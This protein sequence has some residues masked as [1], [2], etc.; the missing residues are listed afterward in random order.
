[1]ADDR[2]QDES[3]PSEES[4]PATEAEDVALLREQ[5]EEALREKDQFRA[6]AQRA[7]ADLVNYK[8]RSSDEQRELKRVANANQLLKTLSVVDDLTRALDLIPENAVAPGWLD[9]L[10][11]V[12][13]NLDNFLESEGV[14]KIEAEGQPF[15]PREHEAVSFEDTPDG[16][17]GMVVSVIR[18][19]YKLHDKVLRASQ[20]TVSK[21]R[22]Q[23]IA[24]DSNQQEA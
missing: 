5:L 9:G 8:N 20:V 15:E 4:L 13:R 12:Q 11:L 17:E 1:M 16:P 18:D 10:R 21:T 7:Q 23:D 22:N 19:G 14:T 2:P 6:M 3:D 24:Q